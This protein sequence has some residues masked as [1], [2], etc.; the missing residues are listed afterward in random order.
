MTN[1]PPQGHRVKRRK[2]AEIK[3]HNI[4]GI[5]RLSGEDKNGNKWLQFEVDYLAGQEDGKCS[6]CGA[7]LPQGWMCLD[8]GEEV[9]TNHIEY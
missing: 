1:I 6:I 2:V 8:G 4:E 7:A 3:L 5:A 9:C